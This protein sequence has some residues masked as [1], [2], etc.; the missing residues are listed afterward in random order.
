[1]I[2][3]CDPG[4]KGAFALMGE[5]VCEIYAM[6]TKVRKVSGKERVVLDEERLTGLIQGIALHH[7]PD[8]LVIERVGGVQGQSAA[9]GFNFGYGVG[10]T[11]ATARS[12]DMLIERVEAR[13]WKTALKCP[14]DKK[15]SRARA[16][17][18]MPQWAHLWP[19]QK[20]EGKAEAAMIG[21]Y[22]L[23]RKQGT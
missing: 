10:L 6:P 8:R 22:W 15:L 5:G 4:L 18:L 12:C 16:S 13:T 7:A 2:L 3:A 21:Y 1:M 11:V 20:D 9:A 14:A 23:N 19:L 17:E